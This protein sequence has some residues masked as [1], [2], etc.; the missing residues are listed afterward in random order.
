MNYTSITTSFN[1]YEIYLLYTAFFFGIGSE[2]HL[3]WART[4][5]SY[6]DAWNLR[7]VFKRYAFDSNQ[8]KILATEETKHLFED[9]GS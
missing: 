2:L 9:L 7:G 1:Y 5:I 4:K 6:N 8:L 3:V